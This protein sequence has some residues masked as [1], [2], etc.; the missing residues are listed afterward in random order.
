MRIRD[1][2]GSNY[3]QFW[4]RE[5]DQID[6]PN[7]GALVFLVKKILLKNHCNCTIVNIYSGT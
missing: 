5:Y 3:F 1:V 7:R 6:Y 4:M 2:S